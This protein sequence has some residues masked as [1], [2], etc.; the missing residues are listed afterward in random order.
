[1]DILVTGERERWDAFRASRSTGAHHVLY[2]PELQPLKGGADLVIDL[3]LDERP[4]NLM[5]YALQPDIPVLGCLVKTPPAVW[6][7]YPGLYAA[8][9]LPGFYS[10]PR[11]E[12][13]LSANSDAKMLQAVM[14]ELGWEYDTVKASAGLVT[15]RTVA[16]IINEAYFTAEEGTASREDIDVSMKLGTNYPFGPFEWCARIG[17]R[18]VY[19]VLRA[20]HTETG[21]GRYRI[22]AAL[23]QEYNQFIQQQG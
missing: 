15:P 5:I 6:E 3:S 22:C 9:W 4:E 8:N 16:M 21:S 17:I 1:M 11:L 18:N 2:E 10:M 7:G 23:E 13:G 12:I 19:E 14:Q 20:V